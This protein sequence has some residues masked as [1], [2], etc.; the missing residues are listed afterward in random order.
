MRNKGPF[1]SGFSHGELRGLTVLLILILILS[2][3]A[4]LIKF[5]Q[6]VNNIPLNSDSI[7]KNLDEVIDKKQKTYRKD[8]NKRRVNRDHLMKKKEVLLFKFD[9]NTLDSSGWIKLGFSRKQTASILRYRNVGGKFKTK[10]DLAKLYVID[11]EKYIQLKPYISLPDSAPNIAKSMFPKYTSIKTD[12][13]VEINSADSATLIRVRGIGSVFA[14]RIVNYRNR[15]GG[16]YKIE[17]LLE[18]YGID[19]L[20]F[21]NLAA[22]LDIDTTLIKKISINKSDFKSLIRHPYLPYYIVKAIINYRER[23]RGFTELEELEGIDGMYPEL[24]QKLRPYILID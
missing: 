10:A 16:F 6:E 7:Q 21:S 2:G 8:S 4:F 17:Q 15:L 9:P 23:H 18:V 12:E 11:S 14:R 1:F 20:I 24:Y 13:L 3:L 19:T 5:D 22:R